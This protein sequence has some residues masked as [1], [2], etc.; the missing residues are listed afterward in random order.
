M[1]I[2]LFPR[3]LAEDP[4][5]VERFHRELRAILPISRHPNL[6]QILDTGQEGDRLY[7][8]MEKVE[9]TSL[10]RLLESPAAVALRGVHGDAGDLPR[11]QHRPPARPPPPQPDAA[12]RPRLARLRDGQAVGPGDHRFRVGGAEPHRHPGHR[13]DPPGCPL[14]PGAGDAGGNGGGGRADRPL[15]RGGDLPRD[16]DRPHARPQVR[17]TEPDRS[18]ALAGD[19]RR[20]PP[21]PGAPAGRAL[22]QRRRPAGRAGAPGGDAGP[23]DADR[24]PRHL[25]GGIAPARRRRPGRRASGR[26]CS[27]WAWRCWCWPCWPVSRSG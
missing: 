27:T 18:G 25:P 1:A 11:P 22:R 12:Q 24:D 15:L 2:K 4:A 16:V 17:A 21:L 13:R 9:G 26:S 19:R 20:G 3:R 6:V 8:V 7:L 23:A 5:A 10:D 14:L